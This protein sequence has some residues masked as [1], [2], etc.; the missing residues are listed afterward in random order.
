MVIGL[1]KLSD[2]ECL[3]CPSSKT[4]HQTNIG[5]LKGCGC[6]PSPLSLSSVS[7]SCPQSLD[8]LEDLIDQ[9][10]A[11]RLCFVDSLWTQLYYPDMYKD[12]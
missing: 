8:H 9:V 7:L 1:C 12:Q 10:P 5:I 3:C 4:K 6:L 11:R 2:H